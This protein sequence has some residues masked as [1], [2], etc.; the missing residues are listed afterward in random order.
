MWRVDYRIAS[1]VI[2]KKK[3]QYFCIEIT[4]ICQI[5]QTG[6]AAKCWIL[7]FYHK[8]SSARSGLSSCL[9]LTLENSPHYKIKAPY[10]DCVF[11]TGELM[12]VGFS[13]VKKTK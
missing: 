9:G 11:S 4:N 2:L 7:Q 6:N 10:L 5:C 3:I 1:E 12:H 13:E 8:V